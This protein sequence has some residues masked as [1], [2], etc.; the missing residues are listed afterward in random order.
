MRCFS[1]APA[2]SVHAQTV[3]TSGSVRPDLLCMRRYRARGM[4][5][6]RNSSQI[7]IRTARSPSWPSDSVL[8]HSE[9]FMWERPRL[10][11]SW[12]WPD[13]IGRRLNQGQRVSLEWQSLQERTRMTST[14][15]GT[16]TLASRMRLALMGGLR[17][18]G[19]LFAS[20]TTSAMA[21]AAA[22]M[23][24]HFFK[25]MIKPL[26]HKSATACFRSQRTIYFWT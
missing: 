20:Q 11:S 22:S 15:W 24:M 26:F 23:P 21:S 16:S 5:P 18:P 7:P 10:T 19:T 25:F 12:T 13:A 8:F 6:E 3:S 17:A 4:S 1:V 14:F 2:R 9:R